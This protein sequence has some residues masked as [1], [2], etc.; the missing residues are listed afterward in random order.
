MRRYLI[1]VSLALILASSSLAPAAAHARIRGRVVDSGGEPVAGAVITLYAEQVTDPVKVLET[2][3]DGSFKALIMDATRAHRMV[4]QAPGFAAYEKSFKVPAGST[5]T[6]FE[7]VLVSEEQQARQAAAQLPGMA[8]YEEGRRLLETGDTEAAEDQLKA[9]VAA[10]P[11]LAAAWVT[12][13]EIAAGRGEHEEALR[14]ARS[15]L[16]EDPEAVPCLAA[17]AN[18]AVK[19]GE[20]EAYKEYMARYSELNPDDPAAIFNEAADFLNAMD[21]DK[22]RPLLERCLEVDPD[23]PKCLYEYGMLLLRAGELAE[24]KATLQHY[25][26]VAPDGPDAAAV[27]E[28]VKYL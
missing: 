3:A 23:F 8:E 18:A 11:D 21:D 9:A 22:A 25:L 28:T 12:L 16:A 10:R 27:A 6:E 20:Q 17:A 26:E 15:C 2:E 5:D 13:A 14:Y 4:V 7:V 1:G 24:A 19:C